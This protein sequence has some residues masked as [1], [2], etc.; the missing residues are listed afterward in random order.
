MQAVSKGRQGPEASN[1]VR[2]NFNH[3]CSLGGGFCVDEISEGVLLNASCLSVILT[4]QK[5]YS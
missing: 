3:E 1:L 5:G 4:F 2:V